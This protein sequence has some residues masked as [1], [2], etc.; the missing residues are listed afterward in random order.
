MKISIIGS[1]FIGKRVGQG[2]ETLKNE[3]IYY[4][5]NYGVLDQLKKDHHTSN[6][7]N[8][9]IKNTN[10]RQEIKV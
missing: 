6:D 4:D 7:L 5:I 2:F 9:V 10:V 8:Y 3:I 1:G